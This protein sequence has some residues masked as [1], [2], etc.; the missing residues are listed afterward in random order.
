MSRLG[1]RVGLLDTDVF[2]PSIPRMMNLVK[3]EADVTEAG[4]LIPLQ[5]YGVKCMSMGFLV[6]ESEAVV[7]R[8]L[9]VM[10]ALEQL[11]RRVE[12][13]A[14]DLLVLD[15][16]PGTGD[17]AL[18]LT[19][20]LI[21]DGAVVISTPQDVALIDAVKGVAMFRKVDVKV[22]LLILCPDPWNGAEYV[23]VHVL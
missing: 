2:G 14:I 1:L 19:Q 23:N 13:G 12:W 11:M 5:N 20:S 18:T 4:M 15:M 17:T 8:G 6:D 3:A 21:I 22:S 7:W 16:P 9:M 10:K